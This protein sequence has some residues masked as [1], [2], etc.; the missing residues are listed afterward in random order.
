MCIFTSPTRSYFSAQCPPKNIGELA[1]LT[2]YIKKG[3]NKACKVCDRFFKEDDFAC[4]FTSHNLLIIHRHRLL[5][6][7][8]SKVLWPEGSVA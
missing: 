5:S 4:T 6:N 3:I 7:S 8:V 2:V 1:T